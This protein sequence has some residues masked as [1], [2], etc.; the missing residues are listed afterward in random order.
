MV[1]AIQVGSKDRLVLEH[2]T[3]GS[4]PGH[5]KSAPDSKLLY[6]VGYVTVFLL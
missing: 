1:V 5:V 4:P 2:M 3:E 6:G